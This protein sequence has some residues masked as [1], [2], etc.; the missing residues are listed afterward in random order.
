MITMMVDVAPPALLSA[1]RIADASLALARP[2]SL[3]SSCLHQGAF[4]AGVH[5]TCLCIGVA[6]WGF[7]GLR[8]C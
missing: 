7:G 8:V 4:R 6:V 2:A 1:P 5:S 3:C